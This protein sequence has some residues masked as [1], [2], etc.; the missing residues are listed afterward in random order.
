M[1]TKERLDRI[2]KR[3][4]T[5]FYTA[6]YKAALLGLIQ[7][8]GK[9]PDQLQDEIRTWL[10]YEVDDFNNPLVENDRRLYE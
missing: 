9:S 10:R 4:L 6:Q 3:V 1:S 2:T 7:F 8:V 5:E